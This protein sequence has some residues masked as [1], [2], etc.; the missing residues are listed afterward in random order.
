VNR[1]TVKLRKLDHFDGQLPAYETHEAAGA[2]IRACL[3]GPLII[4]P[5]EKSLDTHRTIS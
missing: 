5:G 3:K 2:D 1:V 4:K